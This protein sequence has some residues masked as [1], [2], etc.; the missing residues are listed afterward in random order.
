[1][2]TK[3]KRHLT[4]SDKQQPSKR[5]EARQTVACLRPCMFVTMPVCAQ[6]KK[7]DS[8]QPT[9]TNIPRRR[10]P[11]W[12]QHGGAPRV[13]CQ[14]R[15]KSQVEQ[16]KAMCSRN[17]ANG[18][19]KGDA[20][21]YIFFAVRAKKII[22]LPCPW[23][24][25]LFFTALALCDCSRRETERRQR[26]RDSCECL[27][28]RCVVSQRLRLCFL[29]DC[30]ISPYS[31]SRLTAGSLWWLVGEGGSWHGRWFALSSTRRWTY[32]PSFICSPPVS[33]HPNTIHSRCEQAT[34]FTCR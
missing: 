13:Q 29:V 15:Y 14:R 23:Y 9:K 10:S 2:K 5:R 31:S 6:K 19:S 25:S 32:A 24:V 28:W 3:R 17:A 27:A 26:D 7:A 34:C 16:H 33:L 22:A 4:P 18:I 1:M 11:R 12:R 20:S 21:F 8:P 30:S